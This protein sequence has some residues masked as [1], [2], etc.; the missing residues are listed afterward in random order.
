MFRPG[1]FCHFAAAVLPLEDPRVLGT[2]VH[3]VHGV[4]KPHAR[5]HIAAAVLPLEDTGYKVPSEEARLRSS[6][7]AT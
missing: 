7:A 3:G 4:L 1:A 2:V 6:R 5:C